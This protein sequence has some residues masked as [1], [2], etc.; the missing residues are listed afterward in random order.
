MRSSCTAPRRGGGEYGRWTVVSIPGLITSY[1]Y[2]SGS[3]KTDS[4]VNS[5]AATPPPCSD[6]MERME[7]TRALRE[8]MKG[9]VRNRWKL[10]PGETRGEVDWTLTVNPNPEGRAIGLTRIIM[11]DMSAADGDELMHVYT[12]GHGFDPRDLRFCFMGA[13]QEEREL[14]EGVLV[15]QGVTKDL[16]LTVSPRSPFTGRLRARRKER[17][18]ARRT[19]EERLRR[20]HEDVVRRLANTLHVHEVTNGDEPEL[21]TAEPEFWSD[22][23]EEEA[24][25][26]VILKIVLQT[27]Y[28]SLSDIETMADAS[29]S[30]S[31]DRI[32]RF[33]TVS[34]YLRVGLSLAQARS[35]V[36]HGPP[37]GRF[38]GGWGIDGYARDC[39][40]GIMIVPMPASSYRWVP[41]LMEVEHEDEDAATGEN[42]SDNTSS[43]A[44]SLVE[45][46]QLAL[47]NAATFGL[48]DS[49]EEYSMYDYSDDFS[50][51]DDDNREG[52]ADPGGE[53]A[54]GSYQSR[55]EVMQQII[56][57][58][59]TLP[60]QAAPSRERRYAHWPE[61]KHARVC[62]FAI[63]LRLW[64]ST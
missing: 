30:P 28:I 32:F 9:D 54:F 47:D 59:L 56:D 48:V 19:E 64:H 5:G 4:E 49:D 44:P 8:S 43:A 16:E 62:W 46:I 27:G 60:N 34:D 36:A 21:Y 35:R 63:T 33:T 41:Q 42:A 23:D 13:N 55:F 14:T 17:D 6:Y 10:S 40:R 52:A 15:D 22:E 61:L 20:Q 50:S 12:H 1:S 39:R 3:N 38:G 53:D 2:A 37:Q 29:I 24:W 7:L 26:F 18:Q 45:G 57:E 11:F 51:P 25:G 31:V 58:G